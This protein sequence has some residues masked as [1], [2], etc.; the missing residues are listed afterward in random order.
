M[1]C[2][3]FNLSQHSFPFLQKW[4]FSEEAFLIVRILN[5]EI[6]IGK[7]N[8][9]AWIV[10]SNQ[11]LQSFCAISIFTDEKVKPLSA[12]GEANYQIWAEIVVESSSN[13]FNRTLSKILMKCRGVT[14]HPSI[15][16][17]SNNCLECN[18]W[19]TNTTHGI[20]EYMWKE[21]YAHTV[22]MKYDG[23]T[24]DKSLRKG[25]ICRTSFAWL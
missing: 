18:F 2:L 19:E 20:R 21:G 25:W 12:R 3:L 23:G 15:P 8:V 22:S 13:G 7:G 16:I 24:N 6:T 11:M 14:S 1:H 17:F 10:N 5:R 9:S 4:R